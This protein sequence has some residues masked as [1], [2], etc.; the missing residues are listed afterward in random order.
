MMNKQLGIFCVGLLSGA[1]L[2]F[3]FHN[4]LL[5]RERT[6]GVLQESIHQVLQARLLNQGSI[7]ELDDMIERNL[8]QRAMLAMEARLP[9]RDR[10]VAFVGAY[11]EFTG[12][13]PPADLAEAMQS[14]S[15]V[16]TTEMIDEHVDAV[17]ISLANPDMSREDI[18][19]LFDAKT[20][21]TAPEKSHD[22][23][24]PAPATP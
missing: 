8:N 14:N 2:M 22:N 1:I 15:M 13:T 3:G 7:K 4:A 12:K 6:F 16:V 19:K 17:K 9:S 5:K 10:V 20:S 23:S 24:V 11:Y 18:K 21:V